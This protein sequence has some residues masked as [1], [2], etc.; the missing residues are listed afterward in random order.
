MSD[1][2]TA[3]DPTAPVLPE[4]KMHVVMPNAPTRAKV[5]STRL[6]LKGKSAS[7]IRH[8]EID[9]AGTPLEGSFRAGQSFGVVPAGVD[10][11]GKPHKV[12]LYSLASPSWGEDGHGRE[13]HGSDE[14]GDEHERSDESWRSVARKPTPTRATE[15]ERRGPAPSRTWSAL[16]S[17]SLI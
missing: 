7:F 11:A 6:C 16:K 17:T 12:R 13:E 2:E 5:H 3:A 4:A 8:V 10:A 15:D 1:A 14:A 9:I